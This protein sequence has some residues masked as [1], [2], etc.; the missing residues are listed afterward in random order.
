MSSAFHASRQPSPPFAKSCLR[1]C[2]CNFKTLHSQPVPSN[3]VLSNQNYP[4]Y[5][6]LSYLLSTLPYPGRSKCRLV[7]CEWILHYEQLL[8]LRIFTLSESACYFHRVVS[9]DLISSA[10]HVVVWYNGVYT[11]F[12]RPFESLKTSNPTSVQCMCRQIMCKLARFL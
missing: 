9:I 12:I 10:N 11:K 1:P 8:A 7:K 2:I 6:I 3:F 5:P 4:S